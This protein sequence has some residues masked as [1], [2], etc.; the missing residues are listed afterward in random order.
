MFIIYLNLIFAPNTAQAENI[1]QIKKINKKK[2]EW[3]AQGKKSL[4]IVLLVF[5]T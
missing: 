5:V 2:F 4:I 1:L 3:Q